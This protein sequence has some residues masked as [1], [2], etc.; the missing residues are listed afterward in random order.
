MVETTTTEIII[1]V[2]KRNIYE[3]AETFKGGSCNNCINRT[4]ITFKRQRQRFGKSNYVVKML[5]KINSII[6]NMEI[7]YN[8]YSNYYKI[9]KHTQQTN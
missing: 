5:L 6:E 2:V 1:F 9:I 3:Y 4:E 8:N 7:H